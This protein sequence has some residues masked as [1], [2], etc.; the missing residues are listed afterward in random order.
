MPE[1]LR[2]LEEECWSAVVAAEPPRARLT[3]NAFDSA[4]E[5]L[6]DFADLKSPWFTG[7]SQAVAELAEAAGWR[8]GLAEPEVTQLRHAALV[9]SL[10]SH[11]CPQH[12]LGQKRH[13]VGLRA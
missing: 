5:A 10:G 4:L 12:D 1:V 2:E 8:L 11:R 7:H 9:H 13:S 6:G 3:G